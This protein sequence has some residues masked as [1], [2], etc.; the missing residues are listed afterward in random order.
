MIHET[1]H[2]ALVT[3]VFCHD[4]EDRLLRSVL[5]EAK[6]RGA[7]LAVL[8]E[9][10]LSS[11]CP[12]RRTPRDDDA[13]PPGGPRHRRQARA[14]REVGIALLGG[15]IVEDPD[16]GRRH[17]TAL[18]FDD[19]GELVASYD[20]THL[21]EE[22]GFWETAHYE[23]GQFPPE[24]THALGFPLGL[25]ICSD[26]NRPQG[27]HLLAARGAEAIFAP[28]ATPALS[29]P[30]WLLVLRA[31]AV[32]TGCYVVSTNRPRPEQGVPMGGPSVAISPTGQVLVESHDRVA[33]VALERE[34]VRKAR[35]EYPGYLAVPADLYARG[36]SQV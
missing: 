12:A 23:P 10:P 25:Q 16:T 14:A 20:K 5:Q 9:L 21:P 15:A 29:Y 2:V 31:N 18:L 17:N 22:E 13:E 36:W 19:S 7:E 8:P 4:A 11:W 3:E 26:V 34:E 24:P 33:V 32:T 6:D 1:L 28:R 27:F 30:R 35:V